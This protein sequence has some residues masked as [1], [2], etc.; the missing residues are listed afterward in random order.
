MKVLKH[1]ILVLIIAAA[2]VAGAI[3]GIQQLQE[4]LGATAL[5]E[6]GV[7]GLYVVCFAYF[8]GLGAGALTVASVAIHFGREQYRPVARA[9]SVVALAA[10]MLAGIFITADLGRPEKAHLMVTKM[11]LRSPLFWDFVILNAL[12]GVAALYTFVPLRARLIEKGGTIGTLL[13]SKLKVSAGAS[14]I[15]GLLAGPMIVIIPVLYLVTARVFSSLQARPAWHTASLAPTFLVSALLSGLAAVAI[16]THLIGGF[17]ATDTGKQ[18]ARVIAG[19]L[20]VIIVVDIV[21]FFVPLATMQQFDTSAQAGGAGHLSGGMVFELIV[22][23][24]LPFALI[25]AAWKRAPQ[26]VAAPCVLILVGVLAKRWHII[27]SGSLHRNLPLPTGTYSPN[28]VELG[29]SAGIIGLG[30]LVVY[31][32]MLLMARPAPEIGVAGGNS[33]LSAA[34]QIDG[35][36]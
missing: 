25:A 15:V 34:A 20:L 24:L 29:V 22:G 10:L 14:R 4:G 28:G 11:Q 5:H 30:L 9:A 32:L 31:V 23:L 17:R 1:V 7:W 12:I 35:G 6:P 19:G 18:A 8:L 3:A 16:V 26:L 33:A 13:D 21:L 36:Q 27:I 2:L